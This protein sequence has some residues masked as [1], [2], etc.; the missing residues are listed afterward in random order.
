MR[1][2]TL[3][4][5]TGAANFALTS[6]SLLGL[7][8][9]EPNPIPVLAVFSGDVDAPPADVTAELFCFFLLYVRLVVFYC[10]VTHR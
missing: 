3:P 8:S 4:T 9:I 10:Y 5:G 7:V 6:L 1:S 2:N